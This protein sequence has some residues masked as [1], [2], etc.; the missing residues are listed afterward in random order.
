MTGVTSRRGIKVCT[1]G[2]GCEMAPVGGEG[3]V[4]L[5]GDVV[6]GGEGWV[7]ASLDMISKGA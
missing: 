6:V 2:A 3:E 4:R 5:G 7:L 1:E